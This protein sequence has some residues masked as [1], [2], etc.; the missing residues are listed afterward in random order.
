MIVDPTGYLPRIVDKQLSAALDTFPIVVVDGPRAVGKTTTSER[1]AKSVIRLPQDLPLL[2]IDADSTL[3]SLEAPVLI[4]EWQL[5]G[6]DL[7]W[8]LKRMV[9]NDPTPGRFILTGSVEP[10]TYGPTYP[11]TGRA[12]NLTMYP[13][14]I[15]E[16]N[17][18]GHEPGLL[19]R[20]ANDVPN[21]TTLD[22]TLFTLAQLF[23]TGF[24]AAR[25]QLDPAMF[26]TGY[27]ATV[28]QRA[29]DEGRDT[30]RLS[31]TLAVLGVL[32]GQAVPDQRIWE[33]AD[34]NKASWKA[35]EDLLIRTHLSASLPAYS[36]NRLK[37]LTSYPKRLLTDTA[38][39]LALA[40]VTPDD[41]HADTT[42]AGRYIESLVTQQL[43]PQAHAHGGR[44]SH[45]RTS[46][47]GHE[48]DIIVELGNRLIAIEVKG[49]ERPTANDAKHLM[50]LQEQLG[51]ALTHSFVIHTGANTYPIA[52]R[53]W[54]LP[55]HKL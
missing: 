1:V 2:A 9:D 23:T 34:I 51:D 19:E 44:L 6:T 16:A 20:V 24:P 35:Y 29:G 53:I 3:K 32:T 13:M 47:G 31:K 33:A 48:I 22:T 15:A 49:G 38:L 45:L 17:G 21:T 11:L 42:L 18:N 43:R 55:I 10:A 27:A 36:S 40:N 39:A 14:T 41:L 52:E 37:R 4:D 26:L 8:T 7:L 46:A 28:A 12:V 50:W 30:A 54:A 25:D 5:A